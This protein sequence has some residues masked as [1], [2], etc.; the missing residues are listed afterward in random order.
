MW[1]MNE[2]GAWEARQALMIAHIGTEDNAGT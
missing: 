2:L 1:T